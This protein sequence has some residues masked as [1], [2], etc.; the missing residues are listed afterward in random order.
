MVCQIKK[1]VKE[2][3]KLFKETFRSIND[4]T[5]QRK[6]KVFSNQIL[7]MFL[8]MSTN[9]CG[10][11]EARENTNIRALI[12]NNVSYQAVNKKVLSG[13]FSQHFFSLNDQI[14]QKF[15]KK[16]TSRRIFGVDGY[17]V[18]LNSSVNKN[19]FRRV[20]TLNPFK[21]NPHCDI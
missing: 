10:Y 9:H 4:Q 7:Y 12:D 5:I 16:E 1:T 14:I 18:N 15:F 8:V 20:D 17:Q 13:K 21:R 2:L 19:G 6:R 11:Q 3:K